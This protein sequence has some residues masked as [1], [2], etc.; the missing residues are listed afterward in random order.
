M[1]RCRY[2][3]SLIVNHLPMSLVVFKSTDGGFTWDFQAV[4]VNY[5]QIPGMPAGQPNP[6]NL[7]HSAYGQFTFTM[8][9]HARI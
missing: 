1:Q 9:R 7:T 5:T 6:Y 4:A 2:N 8:W 3:Q